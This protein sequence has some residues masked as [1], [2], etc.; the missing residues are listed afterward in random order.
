MEVIIKEF[1]SKPNPTIKDL[2]MLFKAFRCPPLSSAPD[3]SPPCVSQ[4]ADRVSTSCATQQGEPTTDAVGKLEEAGSSDQ[5]PPD[6]LKAT[7]VAMRPNP[8]KLVTHLAQ[9]SPS[10]YE[11]YSH[12][13]VLMRPKRK[14]KFAAT[15]TT[16]RVLNGNKKK[17]KFTDKLL[18]CQFYGRKKMKKTASDFVRLMERLKWKDQQKLITMDL[19]IDGENKT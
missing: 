7:E 18:H 8:G 4:V 1:E 19:T 2:G 14:K 9:T 6:N 12:R 10:M 5:K 16:R 15:T 3:S 17:K 13:R 11:K